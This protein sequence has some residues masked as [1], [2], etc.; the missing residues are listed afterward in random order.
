MG[1]NKACKTITSLPYC[2]LIFMTW[3]CT[4]FK[5]ANNEN[6]YLEMFL[7]GF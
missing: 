2:A 6:N 7:S 5:N 4:H 3:I 1:M